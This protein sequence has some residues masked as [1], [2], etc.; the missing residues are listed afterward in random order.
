M[1]MHVDVVG[2]NQNGEDTA[3]KRGVEFIVEGGFDAVFFAI[4]EAV[5]GDILSVSVRS[6]E[7]T[8]WFLNYNMI[9]SIDDL[10]SVT[11]VKMVDE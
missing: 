4:G 6:L 11:M 7:R 2:R 10:L 9:I 3:N 5:G 1:K 8:H